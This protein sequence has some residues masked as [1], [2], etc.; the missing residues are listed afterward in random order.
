VLVHGGWSN[1]D[2]WQWVRR[3]LEDL[4]VHVQVPDLPSHHS[5]AAGLLQ[6]AAEVQQVIRSCPAPVAVVGWSYGGTVIGVAAAGETN[7]TRLIYVA[8]YPELIRDHGEDVSEL[9]EHPHIIVGQDGMYVLDNDWWLTEEKGTTFSPQVREHLRRH[10]RR[11]ASLRTMTDPLPAAAW[12][13]IPTTVVLGRHDELVSADERA[14]VT[15][16]VKDVRWLD[17]DHFILFR[18]PEAIT[19]VVVEALETPQDAH[20]SGGTTAPVH[21]D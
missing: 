20:R 12:Q 14:W 15:E 19:E 9:E 13:T 21:R 16:N 17:T 2:D 4:D 5:A 11:P 6:D 3:Q 18:Q 10:P 8:S 1:P 7:V